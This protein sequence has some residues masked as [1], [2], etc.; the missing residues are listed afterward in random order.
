MILMQTDARTPTR[1]DSLVNGADRLH[2]VAC[3][4]IFRSGRRLQSAQAGVKK[5]GR[6]LDIPLDFN[7]WKS[8]S[9]GHK[10]AAVSRI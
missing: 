9:V 3:S 7:A 4:D 10:P 2:F 8:V 6:L 1:R 5:A